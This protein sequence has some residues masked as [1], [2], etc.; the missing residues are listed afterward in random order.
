M[1]GLGLV[2]V[3][4]WVRLGV[5]C[6]A[7]LASTG[8]LIWLLKNAP[9]TR[10]QQRTMIERFAR[11]NEDIFTEFVEEAAGTLHDLTVKLHRAV[12]RCS[13]L[14]LTAE[15]QTV[16]SEY[17]EVLGHLGYRYLGPLVTVQTNGGVKRVDDGPVL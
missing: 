1:N 7:L 10:Q 16:L 15:Q 8:F 14:E 12:C 9:F 5:L 2:P 13:D 11:E 6:I 4:L 3:D 17:S